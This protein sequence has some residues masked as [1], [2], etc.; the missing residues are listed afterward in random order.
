MKTLLSTILVALFAQFSF[1]QT[2]VY[3]P[4]ALDNASWTIYT[5]LYN[6]QSYVQD[7]YTIAWSGDTIIGGQTYTRVFDSP[8]M[9]GVRQDIPNE[10]VYFIDDQ[11]LE[12]D[13]SFDQ[14][15]QVGDTVQITPEFKVLNMFS[16]LGPNTEQAVITG[17]GVIQLGST[18]HKKLSF[19]SVTSGAPYEMVY[20]CGV[21]CTYATT[22]ISSTFDIE[23]YYVDGYQLIGSSFN[24]YCTAD[25]EDLTMEEVAVYPNPSNGL[26]YIDYPESAEL[27]EIRLIDLSGKELKTFD[28]AKVESGFDILDYPQGMYIVELVFDQGFARTTLIK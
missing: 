5:Q 21:G 26:F 3:Q 15:V 11:G 6:G 1:A 23:C 12:H 17:E 10:K 16:G 9:I 14:S 24:P 13:A 27:Q 7:W 28:P 18:V 2:N 20:I 8:G 4:Y 25:V 19:E 22:S